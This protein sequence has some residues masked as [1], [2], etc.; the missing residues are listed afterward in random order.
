MLKTAILHITLMAILAIINL[1]CCTA[2]GYDEIL[3]DEFNNMY[4][5]N[6]QDDLWPNYVFKNKKLLKNDQIE[7]D[8]P[9]F[10]DE[11]SY[12]ISDEMIQKLLLPT[13]N[14][15]MN[16]N[17]E[18]KK[19]AHYY[20][21]DEFD[22][23]PKYVPVGIR[24]IIIKFTE[25]SGFK[26][27]KEDNRIGNES[28]NATVSIK[29]NSTHNTHSS[30]KILNTTIESKARL[31]YTTDYTQYR[32]RPTKNNTSIKSVRKFSKG[33]ALGSGGD[34][35]LNGLRKN[36]KDFRSKINSKFTSLDDLDGFGKISSERLIQKRVDTKER[37]ANT[38]NGR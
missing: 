25:I 18:W 17:N 10:D 32:T 34:S 23:E 38:G 4:P 11:N 15:V 8:I 5:T 24:P 36:L 37:L 12:I 20:D 9:L 2:D 14:Q 31:N 29:S 7:I 1:M 3:I 30:H 33:D 13:N 19:D 22:N 6:N 28:V 16:D 27:E 21:I 35:L 26:P